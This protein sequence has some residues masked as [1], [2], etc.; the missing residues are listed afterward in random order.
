VKAR[1]YIG[2]SQ[3]SRS[4]KAAIEQLEA[5]VAADPSIA[6]THRLIAQRQ[7]AAGRINAALRALDRSVKLDPD[8]ASSWYL[9]AT[10]AKN[11]LRVRKATERFLQLEPASPRAKALRRKIDRRR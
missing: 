3:I 5:A 4:N 6:F 7:A 9:I 1:A 2:L 11:R 10:T 8:D